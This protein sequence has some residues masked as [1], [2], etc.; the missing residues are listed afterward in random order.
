M[1]VKLSLQYKDINPN[2]SI[3]QSKREKP[4]IMASDLPF[5]RFISQP[6]NAEPDALLGFS[7]PYL[8]DMLTSP[9]LIGSNA[10]DRLSEALRLQISLINAFW[11]SGVTAWDLRFVGTDE[12]PGV[13]IGL[14]CRLH[15]L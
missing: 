13:A 9:W 14:L 5:F 10:L 8:Q 1:P 11:S 6:G 4:L 3:V 12:L 15:R 7:L 2:A